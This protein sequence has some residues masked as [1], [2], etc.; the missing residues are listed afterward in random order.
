VVQFV[1]NAV[2][3]VVSGVF[4]WAV[5][6]FL[7]FDAGLAAIGAAILFLA[8]L[9][10]RG[11]RARKRQMLELEADLEDLRAANGGLRSALEETKRKVADA[12][13]AIAKKSDAQERKTAGEL[14]LMEG[15]LRD[16]SSA[17][18]MRT[19]SHPGP[20]AIDSFGADD[21][22]RTLTDPA[23]LEIIRRALEENRVDL[24]LQPVV[25][26]PQRKLKFYEALSR[27]RSEDGAV[28]MPAQ[29]IRIAAP[30]GLMSVVDNLLLFRCVQV[31]RR[32]SQKQRA[33]GVFC[34]ISGQTL[35]DAE[36]F[37]QFLDFMHHHRDLA[38][39]IVFEF[40]QSALLKAGVREEANLRYLAGLGFRLS[41]DQV[42]RLDFDLSRARRLGF[43]FLKLRADVLLSGMK[44]AH[45]AVAAEDLKDLLAR[46]GLS[47]IVE[48]VEDEKT[49]V[50]LL[51]YNIELGQGYL[52][53]EPR[54]VRDIA[55]VNDPRAP[56]A[57]QAATVLAPGLARRLAG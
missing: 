37:P 35:C 26:L 4:A 42:T 27:L 47:L 46:N 41:M 57:P 16:L 28:I 45:A 22:Q 18:A 38:G 40:S 53:G 55:E 34:N 15:L 51:E 49:V 5:H 6:R 29:Y 19:L 54:A 12:T 24:Y 13:L 48:R 17:T 32:M 11:G 30:A 20:R 10:I 25:G 50:Q 14:Q 36:F 23:M 3:V 43:Q 21:S 8:A 52:F 31:V 9:Q 44:Q 33:V 56:A 7:D 39:Q 2:M 1:I